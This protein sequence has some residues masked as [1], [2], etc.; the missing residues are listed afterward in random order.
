[1]AVFISNGSP[2]ETT[3][4][5]NHIKRDGTTEVLGNFLRNS[6]PIVTSNNIAT[7]P[8]MAWGR[9]TATFTAKGQTLDLEVSLP[10]SFKSGS[11]PVVVAGFGGGSTWCSK[12][13]ISASSGGT[14]TSKKFHIFVYNPNDTSGTI[15]IHWVAL[16]LN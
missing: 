16:S 3:D 6:V 1:M 13:K 15:A 11:D 10:S 9:T 8:M 5:I 2:I 14:A 7:T 12:L 4:R